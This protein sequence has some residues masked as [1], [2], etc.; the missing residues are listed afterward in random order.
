MFRIS[1]ATINDKILIFTQ[2]VWTD[3]YPWLLDGPRTYIENIYDEK[4]G[5][6]K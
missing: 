6:H 3:P 1:Q 4:A 2:D 5:K